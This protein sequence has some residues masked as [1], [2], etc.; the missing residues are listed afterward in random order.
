ME[1]DSDW[2]ELGEGYGKLRV[3]ACRRKAVSNGG[4]RLAVTGE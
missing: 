1:I 2:R 4:G 3:G